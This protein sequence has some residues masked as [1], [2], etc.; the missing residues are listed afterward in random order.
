MSEWP[1]NLL[2]HAF[3]PRQVEDITGISTDLQR[4]WQLRHSLGGYRQASWPSGDKG[5]LAR[6][7][8]WQGV[9]LLTL[10]RDV[11]GDTSAELGLKAVQHCAERN[12]FAFDHTDR[13]GGGDL[14]LS[15]GWWLNTVRP[16]PSVGLTNLDAGLQIMS[17]TQADG[18][19]LPWGRAA[20]MYFYSLSEMQRA[21]LPR[22]PA[23]LSPIRP[24]RDGE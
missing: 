8:S 15:I 19:T 9:Q 14:Y 13:T 18:D 1:E 16:D 22:L 23:D 5:E 20:R 7:W 10:F 11:F 4:Q 3:R 12:I 2:W 21:L 17:G 24:A 6:R